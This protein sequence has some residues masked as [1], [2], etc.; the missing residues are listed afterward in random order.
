MVDD[1]VPVEIHIDI[2]HNGELFHVSEDL[3]QVFFVFV[4]QLV[5]LTEL[6]DHRCEIWRDRTD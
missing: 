3:Q 5:G 2:D 4:L 6:S 1:C